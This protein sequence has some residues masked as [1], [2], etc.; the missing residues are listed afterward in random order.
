MVKTLTLRNIDIY[1]LATQLTEVFN[2]QEDESNL[3]IKI[4][5]F[6]Q[7][8]INKIIDLA[9][10]IDKSRSEI[11]QKYG[12]LNEEKQEYEVPTEK[13]EEAQQELNDLFAIE[14]EIKINMLDINLFDGVD[15]SEKKGNAILFMIY[16][17]EE[18]I[19]E[20]E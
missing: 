9:Q 7:K 10:D 11:I 5:F 13:L 16:D 3:P 17:P 8:N 15:I 14:Q 2:N 19:E 6:L 1:M 12:A 4:N 20:K 18:E